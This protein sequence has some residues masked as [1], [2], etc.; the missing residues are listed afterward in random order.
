MSEPLCEYEQIKN[1]EIFYLGEI[2][3][4]SKVLYIFLLALVIISVSALPF[5]KVTINSSSPA[6]IQTALTNE[7]V[8]ATV[9]GKIT[10]L[11]FKDNLRVHAGD[12]LLWIDNSAQKSNINVL[13]NQKKLLLDNLND[14]KLFN[15]I[16]NFD[17]RPNFRTRKYQ[18]EYDQMLL[19]KKEIMF[20][21]KKIAKD[22]ERSE[23]LFNRKVISASEWEVEK[24][25]Y[26]GVKS[27]L[28]MLAEKSKSRFSSDEYSLAQ[29]LS[30]ID[31]Q[32]IQFQDA[33][34]RS[35]VIANIS[36][37][38]YRSSGVQQGSFVRLGQQIGEISPTSSLIAVCYVSPKDIGFISLDQKVRLQLDAF[39]YI[40]WGTLIGRVVEI[41]DEVVMMENKPFFVVKCSLETSFL[42]LS[43]G[44]KGIIKKGMTSTANFELTERSLWQLIFDKMHNWLNPNVT[45]Q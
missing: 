21:Y 43:N 7:V 29:E 3:T 24:L 4:S 23:T 34:V 33:N 25:R 13:Q 12:T 37:T 41:N 9:E 20:R 26:D 11:S 27:E 44:R 22:F 6:I 8:M 5:I 28:E 40:D 42:K 10:K 30:N 36:G 45:T 38:I 31:K 2:S 39:S 15:S 19:Q 1:R 18:I 17:G 14:L 16:S 32:I 35:V